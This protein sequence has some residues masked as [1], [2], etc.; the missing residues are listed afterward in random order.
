ME[1]SIAEY[2]NL[3]WLYWIIVTIYSLTIL[4]TIIIILSENR[5][6][7]KSLAWVT[8]LILLPA[9]GLILYIFFGRSIKN[10]HMIS[11]RNR[12]R[13]KRRKTTNTNPNTN[14]L[15][16]TSIS[17]SPESIHQIK[18]TRNLNGSKF[19]SRN[20]I[21]IYSDGHS[22]FEDF[23][24]DLSQAKE[25]INIQYYI[26]ED[27]N[28]GT[29]IKN[30]LIAKASEGVKIRIIYDHVGSFSTKNSF[31]NEM[32]AA[33]IM[34]H[35]FF[36]VSFPFL[37]TRINW[38]NHRKLC[39][40]DGEIG[41]IGGMNIA[42]R[43][44]TGGKFDTWRDTHLRVSGSI[45]TAL[46]YSFTIDWNF[47][48]QSL[49]E[50]ET[51][52]IKVNNDTLNDIGMQFLT[53]GPTDQWSNIALVFLNAISNAKR[54]IIIQTPYFLPTESLLKALQSAALS[55]V[56]VRIMIP[57]HSDSKILRFA[58]YSYINE[59]LKSGIKF[60]FYEAGMLHSKTIIIDNEFS[61]VGSTN[62]DFRSFEHNFEC[63]LFIYSKEV[64]AQ[65]REIFAEDLK[66]STLINSKTWQKRPIIQKV[67]ESI[68]RLLSPIL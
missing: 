6:P 55:N 43:Y 1:Y 53:S 31:F 41:Y 51:S 65:M 37:G 28:I 13:L 33:G 5:N 54:S 23:K 30:I 48:G 44:L 25:Y 39:I 61:T 34:V 35:P 38:R 45:L 17:L 49:L 66:H 59:C 2:I 24:H 9:V 47:M 64:N 16:L 62:F 63:N 20:D 32:K 57:R 36:K 29:E 12:R 10:T 21:K 52:S 68:T 19:Y 50:E 58:S 60:Y 18:L 11:R 14:N 3:S 42:D 26:I 40:I 46:Q 56:N 4:S 8:V 67:T 7:V 27:D 22:K 15:N